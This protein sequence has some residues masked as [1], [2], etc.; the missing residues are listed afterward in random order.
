MTPS[1]RKKILGW[2]FGIWEHR[3]L[4][5]S[6]IDCMERDTSLHTVVCNW[7]VSDINGNILI[8]TLSDFE[9]PKPIRQS[10]YRDR[11]V[12]SCSRT[13]Y[14]WDNLAGSSK[15]AHVCFETGWRPRD[16][17]GGTTTDFNPKTRKRHDHHTCM[18]SLGVLYNFIWARSGGF[19]IVKHQ[20]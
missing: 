3:F 14:K 6:L 1:V 17:T 8:S 19:H 4:S 12:H 2:Q 11:F 5:V 13:Q 15:M 16:C 10:R 9:K 18:W 7:P 20:L